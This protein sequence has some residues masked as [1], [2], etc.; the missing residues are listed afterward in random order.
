[1]S[2]KVHSHGGPSIVFDQSMPSGIESRRDVCQTNSTLHCT[3]AH[4]DS[5]S[6][7]RCFADKARVSAMPI[8]CELVDPHDR[9]FQLKSRGLRYACQAN[10]YNQRKGGK[11]KP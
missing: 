9:K 5:R 11:R 7:F 1:M 2:W 3:Y 4:V 10:S 6:F 8:V